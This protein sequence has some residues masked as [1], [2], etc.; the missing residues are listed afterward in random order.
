M[1]IGKGYHQKQDNL[2]KLMKSRIYKKMKQSF[3]AL[4]PN[5]KQP[6][7]ANIFYNFGITYLYVLVKF[8]FSKKATKMDKIFTIDL[9][10]YSKCQIDGE[11]FIHFCGLLRKHKL[12]QYVSISV[13]FILGVKQGRYPSKQQF[14]DFYFEGKF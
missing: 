12:Y 10:L 9:T 8:I 11:D 5:P 4:T 3:T 6:K 7:T 2:V 1:K 13:L 14:K